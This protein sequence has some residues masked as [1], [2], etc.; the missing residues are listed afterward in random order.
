M[1]MTNA[2]R[3]KRYRNRQRGGPPLGRWGGRLSIGQAAK[4]VGCSRT[5]LFMI[6]W[7]DKYAKDVMP[8]LD[9]PKARVTPA[10]KRLRAEYDAG[11]LKAYLGR[12]DHRGVRLVSLRRDGR[13]VFKWVAG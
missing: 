1:P 8:Q 2:E 12:K 3:Q 4:A 5:I 11:F 13:F 7:I 6:R 10:Y 9:H